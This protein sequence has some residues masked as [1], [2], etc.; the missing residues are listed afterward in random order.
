MLPH[1]PDEILVNIFSSFSPTPRNY[2]EDGVY[3]PDYTEAEARH[4][5]VALTKCTRKLR[6]AA[7]A[8]LYRTVVLHD[9]GTFFLFLRT[10]IRADDLAKR[11]RVLWIPTFFFHDMLGDFSEAESESIVANIA[12]HLEAYTHMACCFGD[13][14]NPRMFGESS[15]CLLLCLATNVETF[16]LSYSGT[17]EGDYAYRVLAPF[18]EKSYL[19]GFPLLPSPRSL[20]VSAQ[21]PEEPGG[22]A[23]LPRQFTPL[24]GSGKISH[25]ELFEPVFNDDTVKPEHW[26]AVE[27]LRCWYILS[28]LSPSLQKMHRLARAPL[29]KLDVIFAI[30]EALREEYDFND[31][32]ALF[33]DTLESLSLSLYPTMTHPIVAIGL[34]CLAQLSNLKELDISAT[35]LFQSFDAMESADICSMLPASLQKMRFD[36]THSTREDCWNGSFLDDLTCRDR[37]G[38]WA[39]VDYVKAL[40]KHVRALVRKSAERL[41]ELRTVQL[42]VPRDDNSAH[43]E[44]ICSL[45]RIEF[46]ETSDGV[47]TLSV[48]CRTKQAEARDAVMALAV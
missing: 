38:D 4:T 36:E 42:T 14:S 44:E 34:T 39:Y 32:V 47:E 46:D 31:S 17:L 35:F 24:L 43:V 18:F 12:S 25:L 41:P 40:K 22:L 2:L 8:C 11:V 29:R 45:G 27:S 16:F 20:S 30:E 9:L 3:K 10:V 48:R 5:L 13:L 23:L 37:D 6:P 15:C 19:D 33:A 1:L 7:T 21:D 28:A 26:G